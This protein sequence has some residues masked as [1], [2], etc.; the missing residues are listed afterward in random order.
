MKICVTNT[1]CGWVQTVLAELALLGTLVI[2]GPL[3]YLP[4][5]L[6]ANWLFGDVQAPL[7][8]LVRPLPVWAASP[9]AI[10]GRRPRAD[11]SGVWVDV[12]GAGLLRQ[13]CLLFVGGT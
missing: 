11:G 12:S 1:F 5:L 8:L 13:S 6:L 10:P 7:D 4:N 9:A 3:G 2:A